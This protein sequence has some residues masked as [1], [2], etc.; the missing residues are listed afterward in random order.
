MLK[1]SRDEN[2]ANYLLDEA[3]SVIFLKHPNLV[4]LYRYILSKAKNE[5]YLIYEFCDGGDLKSY[6][7]RKGRLKLDEALGIIKQI[8]KGLAYL[9]NKGYIHSDIKP[10]NVLAKYENGKLVWK[11]GDFSLLKTRGYSGILDIKGTVGYIAPEVFKGEIHRSSDI[12]SLG[13]LFYF[14]LKG[15]HPFASKN[16]QEELMKNKIGKVEIPEEL[17]EDIKKVFRKMVALNYLDRYRTAGEL[18]KDLERLGV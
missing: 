18:L 6:V 5:V 8:A 13:C 3:Q 10:E 2:L 1:I 4:R 14:T 7:E 17:P 15:V 16:P 11:L 12:F 9:H